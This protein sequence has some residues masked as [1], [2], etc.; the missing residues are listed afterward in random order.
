MEVIQ[1]YKYKLKPTTQQANLLDNW[2]GTCRFVYN[3]ALDCKIQ[4][5]QKGVRLSKYDLM[6]QLPGLKE[7]EWIQSVPSQSLQN[8]IERLDVAYQKFFSGGGFPKWAKRG[9][10]NSILFKSVS[11]T[12][13]GFVL[14][15]VGQLKVFKDRM[16]TGK[17]KTAIIIKE[18]NGYFMC[19]TFGIESKNLY[20]TDENQVVGIDMGIAHFLTDSKGCYVENPKYTKKYQARLRVKNR[21]L[22]RKKK[23]SGR[24]KKTKSELSRLH[25]KIAN[26]RKDFS[27]KVSLKYVKENTLI[28]CEDLK[29]RNM[30]KFG[31]LSKSIADVSWSGFFDK[32]SYKSKLYEKRFVQVNPKFTS[33]KC[34]SCGHIAKENRLNQANFH[35]VSCGHQQN[36]DFNAAKN[37][38][39]EGIALNRQREAIA[40]A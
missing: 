24:F 36:A 2:I 3:L 20:P 7:V 13:T 27:H 25:S 16:P 29:V 39:G 4:S 26:V 6:K 34:N 22:A 17:L 21:S 8:V 33:Q 14:P 10:Y 28:V 23:G 15:K 35:C 11:Q 32:L 19:V 40:C 5:Y 12:A 37:I 18:S 1:T 30:I 38:L 9:E 31:N